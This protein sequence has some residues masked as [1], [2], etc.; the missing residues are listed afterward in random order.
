MT[1]LNIYTTEQRKAYVEDLK[2]SGLTQKEYSAL[3]GLKETTLS[4]W[5]QREKQ[6][7]DKSL[8]LI[9][10]KSHVVTQ[11]ISIEYMGAKLLVNEDSVECVFRALRKVNGCAQ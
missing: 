9:K 1:N 6:E 2:K 10:K 5:V 8:V 7:K 11:N 4:T 3:N